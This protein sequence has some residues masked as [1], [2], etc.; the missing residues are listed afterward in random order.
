MIISEMQSGAGGRRPGQGRKT[1]RKYIP[2]GSTAAVGTGMAQA[3]LSTS[4]WSPLLLPSR[5]SCTSLC[6]GRCGHRASP[7]TCASPHIV[8]A[9][10]GLAARTRTQ[11]V[12]EVRLPV[13]LQTRRNEQIE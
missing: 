1:R 10:D 3:S 7:D 13:P 4:S 8:P 11:V 5:D 9:V 12:E 2:V 6:I